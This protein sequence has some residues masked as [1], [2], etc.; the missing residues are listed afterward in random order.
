MKQPLRFRVYPTATS[1]LFVRVVVYDS[2]TTMLAASDG[3]R[4]APKPAEAV[5]D[6]PTATTREWIA[7]RVDANGHRRRDPCVAEIHLVADRSG[8][9]VVSH[10]AFHATLA[11]GRRIRFDWK[12]LGQEDGVLAEE[13]LAYLHGDICRII[14]DRLYQAGEYQ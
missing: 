10:E 9:R 6:V 5:E 1:R 7:W 14:V 4:L 13:A 3:E 12:R 11:W 2:E 8:M